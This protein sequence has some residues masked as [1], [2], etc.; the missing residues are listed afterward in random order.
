MTNSQDAD[1]SVEAKP[2]SSTESRVPSTS[3]LSWVEGAFA[4]TLVLGLLALSVL[5]VAVVVDAF[6]NGHHLAGVVG[7]VLFPM[8]VVAA[9]VMVLHAWR[10]VRKYPRHAT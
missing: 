6:A 1:N 7:A 3:G 8:W 2:E 4:G 9:A 10:E 5:G